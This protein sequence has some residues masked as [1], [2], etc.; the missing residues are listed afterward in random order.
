MILAID[1]ATRWT[2]LAL[3]DGANIIAEHGWRS[4]NK[5]SVELAPEVAGMLLRA[6]FHPEA[7]KG[8]A[9]AIGPG[10]YTGLRIGL[11]L[12]K[13]MAL[14]HQTPIIGVPTLDIVAAA[15]PQMPGKLIVIAEAGRRRITAAA[16]AWQASSGWL[17]PDAPYNTTWDELLEAID[18]PVVLTG[19]ISPQAMKRIRSTGKGV[20]AVRAV[21]RVRRAGYLAEVGWKRLRKG[22]VDDAAELTPI[23]LREL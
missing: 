9:V 23:Y 16:Y 22:M 13:G 10:S 11:G 5:Q 1:T 12:A 4:I 20:R 15:L 19:E 7:L 14:A 2:G 18:S 17:A 6:G 3:H 8:I 21:D